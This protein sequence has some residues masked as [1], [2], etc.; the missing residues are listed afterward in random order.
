MK[1]KVLNLKSLSKYF[2]KTF[3]LF[4]TI[5]IL[6]R[7]LYKQKIANACI[8]INCSNFIHMIGKEINLF[9]TSTNKQ[10]SLD[11]KKIL[12]QEFELVKLATTETVSTINNS[13]DNINEIVSYGN[14]ENPDLTVESNIEEN[15]INEPAI[16]SNN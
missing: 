2:S 7:F 11:S 13:E 16:R 12:N 14:E 3:F 9:D 1:I 8:K 10:S 15:K 4:I 5:A 6:S